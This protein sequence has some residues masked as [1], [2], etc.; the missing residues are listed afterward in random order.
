[1]DEPSRTLLYGRDGR[2]GKRNQLDYFGERQDHVRQVEVGRAMA[3]KHGFVVPAAGIALA[4]A[5]MPLP[6]HHSMAAE[7]DMSQAVTIQGVVTKTEWMNPHAR[8]F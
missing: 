8:F 4:F 5:A 1:M 2:R 3:M 6:A 7:Y